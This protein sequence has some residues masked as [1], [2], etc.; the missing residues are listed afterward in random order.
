MDYHADIAHRRNAEN[1]NISIP[2]NLL[3]IDDLQ[4]TY[5][6]LIN[7]QKLLEYVGEGS[8]KQKI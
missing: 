5:T 4:K 2:K 3:K 1:S 8:K 6:E 7:I